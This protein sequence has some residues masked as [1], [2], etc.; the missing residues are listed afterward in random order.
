MKIL[1][2]NLHLFWDQL[3]IA[4]QGIS[5]CHCGEYHDGSTFKE[6]STVMN[7][8]DRLVTYKEDVC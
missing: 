5:E 6:G 7:D 8:D 4:F 3:V 2:Q 1:C